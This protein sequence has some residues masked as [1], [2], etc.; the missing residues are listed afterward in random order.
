MDI[1]FREIID[2]TFVEI[3]RQDDKFGKERNQHPLVWQSIL[4][5]E[6]GE[7]AKEINDANFDEKQLGTNYRNELIQIV[8]VGLQAVYNHDKQNK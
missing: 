8:A 7:V 5:E 4:M 3:K 6:V 1:R 2:E